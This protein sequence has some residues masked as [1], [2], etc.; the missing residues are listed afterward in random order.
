MKQHSSSQTNDTVALFYMHCKAPKPLPQSGV[1]MVVSLRKGIDIEQ[2]HGAGSSFSALH[3]HP[4]GIL[5]RHSCCPT[6][7][8][9]IGVVRARPFPN[10]RD[11]PI[12][13]YTY[14]LPG[15]IVNVM[16]PSTTNASTVRPSDAPA[17]RLPT[18]PASPNEASSSPA[19]LTEAT[20]LGTAA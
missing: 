8:P 12:P 1:S 19:S 10:P 17:R 6:A 20:K 7:S 18:C 11:L 3:A 16:I 2:V 14:T 9:Y 15:H 5:F 4:T 13:K